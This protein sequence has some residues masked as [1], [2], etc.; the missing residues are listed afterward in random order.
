MARAKYTDDIAIDQRAPIVEDGDRENIVQADKSVLEDDYLERKAFMEEPVTI[1]LGHG[2]GQNPPTAYYCS[3]NGRNPEILVNG[4]WKH[5]RDPFVMVGHRLTL[6][7]KYVEVLARSKVDSVST[8]HE[9]ANVPY[10]RNEIRHSTAGLCNLMVIRD[11]N[12]RGGEWLAQIRA[13]QF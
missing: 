10:P 13:S 1:E 8:F 12:P 9:E 6:K 2:F 5:L 11:D 4:H 7:R 3:V